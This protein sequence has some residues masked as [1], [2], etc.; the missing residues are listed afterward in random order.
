MEESQ[1]DLLI[2]I[3]YGTGEGSTKK[4]A[5]DE[6]LR[7]CGIHNYNLI[8]L[9]SVIPEKSNVKISETGM[10]MARTFEWG[11]RLYVVMAKMEHCDVLNSSAVA[12]LG[13]IQDSGGKGV[14]VEHQGTIEKEVRDLIKT[15]LSEMSERR[16]I[17]GKMKYKII[18]RKCS[19]R[20]VCAIVAAVYKS[21]DWK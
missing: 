12:G 17:S 13:W 19:G 2:E 4:S 16:E 8:Y 5:F 1:G 3:V 11:H 18:S 6:A 9:S 15:S 7:A 14:F 21:Q 20:P 10:R